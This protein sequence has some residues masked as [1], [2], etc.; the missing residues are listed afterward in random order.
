MDRY[1]QKGKNYRISMSFGTDIL[2]T[3]M[4]IE[5][6]FIDKIWHAWSNN[7]LKMGAEGCSGAVYRKADLEGRAVIRG[8]ANGHVAMVFLHNAV[9]NG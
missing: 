7:A 4:L 6:F 8:T 2:R 9:Q 3:G 5:L 1:E